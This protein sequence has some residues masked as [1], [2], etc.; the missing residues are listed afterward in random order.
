MSALDFVKQHKVLTGVVVVF[1]VAVVWIISRSG[2][3]SQAVTS[4]AGVNGDQNAAL[5]AAQIQAQTASQSIQASLQASMNKDATQVQLATIAGQTSTNNNTIAAD[6]QKYLTDATKS[7]QL[8]T[9]DAQVHVNDNA[10][11]VNRDQLYY[12]NI[13]AQNASNL[14]DIKMNY[15]YLRDQTQL[16]VIQNLALNR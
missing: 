7:V 1:I 15:D 9:I 16:G 12:Q 3:S 13:Q 5:E 2:G 11:Q 6:V 10:T 14:A 4:S 8:S